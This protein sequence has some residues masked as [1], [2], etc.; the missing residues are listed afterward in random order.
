MYVFMSF[1]SLFLL[2]L[3]N[4]PYVLSFITL[5]VFSEQNELVSL[6]DIG[7]LCLYDWKINKPEPGP[8]QYY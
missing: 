4:H 5:V 7:M 2:I 6:P 1:F 8:E 3:I